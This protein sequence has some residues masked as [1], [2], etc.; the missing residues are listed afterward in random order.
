M[1]SMMNSLARAE[2]GGA[3]TAAS[4]E[5]AESLGFEVIG[6]LRVQAANPV[7]H[8]FSAQFPSKMS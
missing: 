3:F 7:Y 5:S 8:R 1:A 6:S 2:G 4:A